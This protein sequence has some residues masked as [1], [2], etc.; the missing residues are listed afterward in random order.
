MSGDTHGATRCPRALWLIGRDDSSPNYTVLYA[1]ARG[2]SRVYSMS[3]S[4]GVWMLWREAPGFWQR[5]EGRMSTNG[6]TI[7]AHWERSAD[8]ATWEHDFDITYTRLST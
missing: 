1:D 6:A 3:F 8:G 4:A 2:V 7:A 5:Y